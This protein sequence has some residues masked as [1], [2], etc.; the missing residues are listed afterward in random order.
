MKKHSSANR[1]MNWK[2]HNSVEVHCDVK[3]TLQRR[4]VVQTLLSQ[5]FRGAG[6][7]FFASGSFLD[8][9]IR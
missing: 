3:P 8:Y 5:A 9:E 7:S 6:G 1:K 2:E 4:Y